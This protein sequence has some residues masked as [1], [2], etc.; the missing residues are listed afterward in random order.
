MGGEGMIL[1]E[2][3]AQESACGAATPMFFSSPALHWSTSEGTLCAVLV[4]LKKNS[5]PILMMSE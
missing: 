2:H 1:S 3:I 4:A 5:F